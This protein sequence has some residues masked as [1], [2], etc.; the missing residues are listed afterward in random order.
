MKVLVAPQS[1][2]YA[3]VT[4]SRNRFGQYIRTRAIPV[5]PSSSFQNTVRARLATNSAAWRALTAVQRAGWNDLAGSMPRTDSLGQAYTPTG[6]GAYVGVNN[7]NV[8]AGNAVVSDAPAVVTPA[9]L[10]IGTITLTA[11]AFTVAYTTTPLPAGARCFAYVSPQ[12]SA[13]RAFNGDWRLLQVSA[14]A[15]A[16]PVNLFAAYQARLGTPVVGNRVFIR[17]ECYQTGFRSVAAV[18]S[19]VV[20]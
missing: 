12:V 15:A 14:A 16:S 5:N 18:S 13:G 8:A 2:S 4:A 9:A 6:F 1:G 7:N 20:A 10:T 3:G 19:A 17:L 11:A